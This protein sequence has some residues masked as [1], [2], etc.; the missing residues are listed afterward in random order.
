M[1]AQRFLHLVGI[2]AKAIQ[3]AWDLGVEIQDAFNDLAKQY[4]E[5]SRTC[6]P[7]EDLATLFELRHLRVQMESRRHASDDP[8]R[9]MQV[10]PE[11]P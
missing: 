3:Q 7:P 8:C 1:N 2:R 11:T 5:E 9:Y 10:E 4:L 6:T